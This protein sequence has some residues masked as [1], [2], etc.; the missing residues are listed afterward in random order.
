[1]LCTYDSEELHKIEVELGRARKKVGLI[2]NLGETKMMFSENIYIVPQ[3]IM[4]KNSI[5]EHINEQIHLTMRTYIF[6]S[7]RN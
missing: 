6:K 7:E 1:M 4:V 3:Q 5:L 2:I